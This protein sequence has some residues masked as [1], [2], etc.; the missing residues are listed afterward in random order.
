MTVLFVDNE[1]SMLNSMDR[2]FEANG[3]YV[4]TASSAKDALRVLESFKVDVVVSD[5]MMPTMRGT[6]LANIIKRLY[7]RI[8][9]VILT[10]YPSVDSAVSAV[11]GG[12]VSKYITKPIDNY[13]LMKIVA[14]LAGVK[15][16]E[17]MQEDDQESEQ[18]ACRKTA[19][20]L[21]T[22]KNNK[23]KLNLSD[24]HTA[25][26][27]LEMSCFPSDM[28]N[29]LSKFMNLHSVMPH[30]EEYMIL[31]KMLVNVQNILQVY[32][33]AFSQNLLGCIMPALYGILISLEKWFESGSEAEGF[34][35]I[36]ELES[37]VRN[38]TEQMKSCPVK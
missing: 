3:M 5:E 19:P 17:R 21:I 2:Y 14:E 29:V 13:E 32:T 15:V 26:Y 1:I 38:L 25:I 6:V 35:Y 31:D 7:P 33:M 10:G 23:V 24:L 11:N 9:I 12:S 27:S 18:K 37:H 4:I 22:E 20:A 34:K 30:T 8:Q 36:S 28:T 16:P